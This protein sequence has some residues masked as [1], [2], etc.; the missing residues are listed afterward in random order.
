MLN[1]E[2][3]EMLIDLVEIKLSYFEI[4]DREDVKE[5]K[6]LKSCSKELK[7]FLTSAKNEEIEQ[8]TEKIQSK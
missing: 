8:M 1:K 7:K 4:Q 6:K 2:L 3:I 5:L